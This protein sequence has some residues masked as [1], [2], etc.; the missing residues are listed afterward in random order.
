MPER[1][2]ELYLQDILD[3]IASIEAYVRGY[4]YEDFFEDR[5]TADAVVRNLEIIGEAAGNMPRDVTGR[6]PEV[7]W[8]KMVGM[9]NKV[10][11]EYAGV[12][13]SILWQTIGE[14]LSPLKTHIEKIR[15][16][17]SHKV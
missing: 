9:R 11:H 14:D 6:Y 8:A 2:A 5:K 10:I 13:L 15:K 7:P 12:D 16:H 3:A 4:S 17:F 1:P